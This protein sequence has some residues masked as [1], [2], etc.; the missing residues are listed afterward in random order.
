MMALLKEYELKNST[1]NINMTAVEWLMQNIEKSLPNFIEAW[2]EEFE[3]A[4]QME[5]EQHNETWL[6][7][8]EESLHE[9]YLGRSRLFL[10]YFKETYERK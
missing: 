1:K 6:T 3:Q 4:K 10:E 5:K 9:N 7:A 8:Q 2:R